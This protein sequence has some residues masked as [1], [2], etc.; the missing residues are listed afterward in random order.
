MCRERRNALKTCR[1]LAFTKYGALG[2]SSRL[3]SLQY[4]PWFQ[5][6]GLKVV[7]QAMLHDDQLVGRYQHGQ[8]AFR[9]LLFA[10]GARIKALLSRRFFDVLWIE[11]EA[12][13]WFPLWLELL[14]LRGTPFVLDYDDAV[15]H[16][17]DKHRNPLV[18]FFYG[19]RLD[20][21]MVKAALVIA[22]NSYLAQRAQQAGARRVEIIPTVIDLNRYPL[23]SRS[24]ASAFDNLPRIVW[25]GSPATVHYL[26]LLADAL[27][28]LAKRQPFVLRVIGGGRFDMPGVPI[29]F[30]QWTESS[31]VENIACCDVGIMP[32]KDSLWERGKCGYKLIQY[33][34]C[35]L[36]VVASPIGV[37]TEIVQHGGNGYLA[38]TTA[39]WVDA[40]EAL[41][42]DS[43]LRSRMGKEGRQR[44]EAKYCIQ[45]TGPI[46]AEL[47]KEA[48][49]GVC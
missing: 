38:N 35:S 10:Y 14:M 23:T 17:Y 21:L 6:H 27:R 40:L 46:M 13:Q 44:V 41:L 20:G 3:R 2:A 47:L 8:Y 45:K 36:P 19:R 9:D 42:S 5:S 22:G 15:F 31:E 24:K 29:E 32:L 37:N 49:Q 12:L 4:L 48:A 16:N 33:M 43:T 26:D 11:K 28:V 1:L 7:V 25:I 34:A 30:V 39:E 18:R